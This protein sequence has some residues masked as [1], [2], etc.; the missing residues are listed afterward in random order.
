VLVVT[1]TNDDPKSPA[2]R[3]RD[4]LLSVEGQA[5]VRESGYVPVT[6]GRER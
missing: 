3:L 2:K 6:S 1:R 5:V 4:W